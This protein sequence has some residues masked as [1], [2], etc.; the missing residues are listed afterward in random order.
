MILRRVLEN[1]NEQPNKVPTVAHASRECRAHG[2]MASATAHPF[3]GCL[4]NGC[5]AREYVDGQKTGKDV[6]YTGDIAPKTLTDWEAQE[7]L[8][9]DDIQQEQKK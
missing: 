2:C 7:P 8:G 3:E 5:A 4:M 9:P 1:T 6:G